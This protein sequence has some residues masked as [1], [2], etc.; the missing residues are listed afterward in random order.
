MKY[1]LF[2]LIIL[3][4]SSSFAQ[5]KHKT[6]R[7]FSITLA[8]WE[9]VEQALN[10]SITNVG[11]F[12]GFKYQQSISKK[13]YIQTALS[14]AD[15]IIIDDCKNCVD[16]FYGN[17]RLRELKISGG[18]GLRYRSLDQSIVKPITEI[19][20]TFNNSTYKGNFSGGF[21]GGGIK[22]N[23]RFNSIGLNPNIGL[24]V[25]LINKFSIRLIAGP[26]ITNVFEY[27]KE[28]LNKYNYRIFDP[29]AS[30]ELAFYF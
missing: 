26:V 24:E 16:H 20:A 25:K 7:S 27:D 28:R 4:K 12:G 5:E 9:V 30:I 6:Q 13:I 11:F 19:N 3:S 22:V 2:I 23:D 14:Y 8:D 15:K 21:G 10:S 18:A 1:I 29:T 17:G